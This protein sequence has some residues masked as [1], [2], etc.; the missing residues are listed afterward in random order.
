[1]SD[2]TR[3]RHQSPDHFLDNF[4]KDH[5]KK[6]S[7]VANFVQRLYCRNQ[8]VGSIHFKINRFSEFLSITKVVSRLRCAVIVKSLILLILNPSRKS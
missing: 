7:E 2:L 5:L 6:R 1:M 3:N 4:I 8:I